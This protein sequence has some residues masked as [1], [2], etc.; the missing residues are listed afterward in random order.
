MKLGTR[1]GNSVDTIRAPEI[2]I[3]GDCVVI[4]T[5]ECFRIHKDLT[6]D[7]EKASNSANPLHGSGSD[8]LF[9]SKRV[10]A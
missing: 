4:V 2:R 3:V 9:I 5:T 10:S 8:S 6:V 1:A 7:L